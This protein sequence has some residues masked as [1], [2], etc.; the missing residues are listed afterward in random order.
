VLNEEHSLSQFPCLQMS[1]IKELILK[2]QT[3]RRLSI[4]LFNKKIYCYYNNKMVKIIT[5]YNTGFTKCNP[6]VQH[7]LRDNGA[8]KAVI[9]I[10]II[11]IIYYIFIYIIIIILLLLLLLLNSGLLSL[12]FNI[13][14]FN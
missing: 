1:K 13:Q 5:E 7:R 4:P 11:I 12:C 10:I 2:V 14:E 6:L 8:T 9:I 3:R